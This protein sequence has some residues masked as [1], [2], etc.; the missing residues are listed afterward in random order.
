MI[1][2]AVTL[3]RRTSTLLP[4]LLRPT[5]IH[6]TTRAVL[7]PRPST[8]LP[9]RQFTTTPFQLSNASE[10]KSYTYPTLQTPPAADT[11]R[12]LIDVREPAEYSAGHIPGAVNM[13]I[14]SR[15]D[16]PFLS[17]DEFIDAFGF[18]LPKDGDKKTEV[19]FYCKAGIRSSAAARMA[20]EAGWEGGETSLGEY[21]GSWMDWVEN[22]GKVEK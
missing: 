6:T 12:L 3:L 5:T 4:R 1:V 2:P 13:P 8:I 9:T 20:K 11:T 21:R 19:V 17:R 14:V 7:S 15:P 16:A 18:E 10:V 22:G